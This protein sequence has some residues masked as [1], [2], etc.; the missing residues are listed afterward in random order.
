[1]VTFQ[2][3]Y[4]HQSHHN[5]IKVICFISKSENLSNFSY[6]FCANHFSSLIL[7]V[8]NILKASCVR[9]LFPRYNIYSSSQ[10]FKFCA[11]CNLLWYYYYCHHVFICV[12]FMLVFPDEILS[13]LAK[14]SMPSRGGV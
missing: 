10:I 11:Y 7:K 2:P 9:R 12:N 3:I 8:Y 1:M 4:V 5:E 14:I 13:I 6:N